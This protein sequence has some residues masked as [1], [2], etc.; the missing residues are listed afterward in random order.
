M[1][2]LPEPMSAAI[3]SGQV[4]ASTGRGTAESPSCPLL[5]LPDD[6]VTRFSYP[7]VAHRCHAASKPRPID[8]GHQAAFC[9]VATFPEC[10]R[11]R[12]AVAPG[13]QVV[14]TPVAAATPVTSAVVTG[15]TR[16][17]GGGPGTPAGPGT[18]GTSGN[19]GASGGLGN[20]GG[21]G[22]FGDPRNPRTPWP[23][24][25]RRS[26][27]WAH[28]VA[29]LIAVV[30]LAGAAYLASPAI[31]DWIRQAGG[32]AAASSPSPSA[33][34]A[35][36][37]AT[38]ASN[39]TVPGSPIT[40]ACERHHRH[41]PDRRRRTLGDPVT[42]DHFWRGARAGTNGRDEFGIENSAQ[43]QAQRSVTLSVHLLRES[44]RAAR[45]F[46]R[47]PAVTMASATMTL[48]RWSTRP[49]RRGRVAGTL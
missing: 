35:S 30:V 25:P 5:G 1:A 49:P 7:S 29:V 4:S 20:V 2:D 48:R 26:R 32:G 39:S 43:G 11:Y 22:N 47:R 3:P 44:V 23:R 19:P 27:R 12:A 8:L 31:S 46:S 28:A 15:P 42:V 38:S 13:R 10:A 41:Q 9:L 17:A 6:R 45:A 36:T 24:H 40:P 21:P 14:A 16:V 18:S 33:T 37:A 34:P